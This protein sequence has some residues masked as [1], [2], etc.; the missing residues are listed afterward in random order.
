[1]AA[2][3]NFR[4]RQLKKLLSLKRKAQDVH[5]CLL[6][7]ADL[8]RFANSPEDFYFQLHEIIGSVIK[9][10][11]L[12]VVF[13]NSTSKEYEFLYYASQ[14][15]PTFEIPKIPTNV[16]ELGLTGYLLRTQKPLLC[17]AQGYQ[18]LL[19]QGEI[20]QLGQPAYSWL[21]VPV[22]LV[23][24]DTGAL[25]IQSYDPNVEFTQQDLA[26]LDILSVH[27][28]HAIERLKQQTQLE[29]EILARSKALQTAKKTLKNEVKDK[30]QYQYMQRL[31]LTL[32]E[33]FDFSLP[34]ESLHQAIT[35]VIQK[36]F[37][38]D[39]QYIAQRQVD[40][41]W[42]FSFVDNQNIKMLDAHNIF[43]PFNEY[44]SL[45]PVPLLLSQVEINRLTELGALNINQQQQKELNNY[46]WVA[47][48]LYRPT[49]YG[50][51]IEDLSYSESLS[52]ICMV[53]KVQAGIPD[54]QGYQHH[55]VERFHFL[56][57]QCNLLLQKWDAQHGLHQ[58]HFELERIIEERTQDLN[59]A[60]VN[61]NQ[62]ITQKEQA[63]AQL[64]HDANHDHL[65]GLPNRQLFNR[66][67]LNAL[68]QFH[69]NPSA[70]YGVLFIDLDRF[71]IIN[72]TFGHLVSD[73][74]LIEVSR[75]IKSCLSQHAI[76]ARMG[77]D[78]FVIL[79]QS[80]Q[81]VKVA[82][83]IAQQI[84]DNLNTCF[85]IEGHEIFAGCSIG[86]TSSEQN[87]QKPADILRDADTAMYR[88][89][90]LGKGCYVLFDE[91]LHDTL[92]EQLALESAL[93]I[94]IKQKQFNLEY[95]PIVNLLANEIVALE[96][97]IHWQHPEQG[98]IPT[99]KFIQLA[100]QTGLIYD[101]DMLSLEQACAYLHEQQATSCNA[102]TVISV[103]LD[104]LFLE[105]KTYLEPL[106]NYLQHSGLD[107]HYLVLEFSETSIKHM[108]LAIQSI[109]KLTQLGVR[110]AIDHFGAR[111]G[112][113]SLL[114]EAKIDF[115]KIDKG[116]IQN[117]HSQIDKQK[118]AQTI[119]AIGQ[120]HNIIMIADGVNSEQALLNAQSIDC[121]FAQGSEIVEPQPVS[122]IQ[123]QGSYFSKS[124]KFAM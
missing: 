18:N 68:A 15:K 40:G 72:D 20:L 59:S 29:R 78:E 97:Q 27:I 60:N 124:R 58:T 28:T 117:L 49:K 37:N 51:Q 17:D 103:N 87:Y 46:T 108:D 52:C 95:Q 96:I 36:V 111:S 90:H 118:Y 48:P 47:A 42:G 89:K 119:L 21:G 94:A 19:Q 88:A 30:T 22:Q 26:I 3:Q 61:L 74:F 92:V 81:V 31:L 62:Q 44:F 79:L 82:Q 24:G 34:I 84:L 23:S 33:S 104:A 16:I 112:S 8:T 10:P 71:K 43:M 85:N 115:V 39:M 54:K 50:Q 63:Q 105:N 13:K 56:V 45:D 91:N 1:M 53:R 6:E 80:Q 4:N 2:K 38:P 67:L 64:Y 77:G 83:K 66:K 102:C 35:D 14:Q 41:Q 120:Q 76:L 121:T 110:V 70:E 9:A 122:N 69:V 99:R 123:Q 113:L 93:R 7:I 57:S 114:F 109:D 32:N 116:L 65:T 73:Q 11:N 75:R 86:I 5:A 98:L 55:D 100:E 25:V 107:L 106:F 101:I 12:Y